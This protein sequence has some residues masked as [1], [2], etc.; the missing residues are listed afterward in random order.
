MDRRHMV[1]TAVGP[2]RPGVVKE[3]SSAIHEAGA[4]LEDSRMAILA[5]DFALIV[6]FSGSAEAV[7]KIQRKCRELEQDLEFQVR[8]KPATPHS[9]KTDHAVFE[10]DVIGVDQPGI[11]HRVSGVLADLES[12]LAELCTAVLGEPGVRRESKQWQAS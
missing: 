8:F 3:I 10:L 4:N 9:K 1:L 7:E 2:D 5:G 12:G 11:V 6:L